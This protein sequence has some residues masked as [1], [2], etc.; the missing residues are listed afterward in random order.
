MNTR[1]LHR[2]KVFSFFLLLASVFFLSG[3]LSRFRSTSTDNLVTF[4]S[5]YTLGIPDNFT[6]VSPGLVENKQITNQV[7]ASYKIS[8]DESRFEDNIVVTRS[9]VWPELD[10]EQ[11]RSLNTKNLQTSLAWYIPGS[12]D[13]VRLDCGDEKITGLYVTFDVRNTLSDDKEITYVSQ[14][15]RVSHSNWYIISYA[16]DNV[17][18]RDDSKKRLSKLDC[19]E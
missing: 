7:L 3:C 4:W 12:Q 1:Y 2:S 5:G 14:L 13:R 8:T 17:S 19:G 6:E 15:Q 10:Y 16:T 18:D 11:F 9:L